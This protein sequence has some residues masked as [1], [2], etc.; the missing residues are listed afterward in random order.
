MQDAAEARRAYDIA[1][2]TL[3]QVLNRFAGRA[4]VELAADAAL[5]RGKTSVGLSGSFT[6]HEGFARLLAGHGLQAVRG[7]NGTYTLRLEAPPPG[8]ANGSRAAHGDGERCRRRCRS[9]AS[10]PTPAARWHARARLGMLGNVDMMDTPFSVSSYTAQNHRR[11]AG[12]HGGRCAGQRPLRALHHLGRAHL[13]RITASAASR[14]TPMTLRS[15][16]C[17]ACRQTAI[18]PPSS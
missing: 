16:A 1:P 2:G 10:R 9:A 17:T 18:R 13:T 15:A 8:S 12:Q 5:T 4:G 11:P 7:G 6:V 3:D 14:S